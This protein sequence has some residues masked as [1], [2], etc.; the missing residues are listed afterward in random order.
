LSE[1]DFLADYDPSAFPSVA[2]TVDIALFTLV[3]DRLAVLLVQRGGHPYL[4]AWALP[5]GFVR[6][7]ETIEDAA[8]RELA[9]ETGVARFDGHL[10]QLATYGDPDRDPRM[11]VVSVAHVAIAPQLPDP[12][13]GSDATG[14]RY[15]AV[16]DLALGRRRR[17]APPL[18]FDHRTI[19]RDALE[20]VRSKLE[21]TSLATSFLDAPFTISA[22][23]RVY[24]TVWGTELDP[25]NFQRKLLNTPGFVRP[26]ERLAIPG[27]SGGRRARLYLPGPATTLH[28]AV[29]RSNA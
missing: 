3:D 25:G 8:G 19:L 18:A 6:P 14:A 11:R 1:A 9:E 22:L 13:A 2:V 7:D 29:L 12:R 5:G 27:S 10:E 21:Y 4:G 17:S 24:E 20:R 26:T 23:R 28:P 15:W 16:D